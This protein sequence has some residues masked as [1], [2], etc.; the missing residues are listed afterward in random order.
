MKLPHIKK[1]CK[2]CPMRKDTTKGW[3]GE[4][5]MR[6]ILRAESF[7]CHKKKSMQCAGHMLIK[8][9]ENVFVAVAGRLGIKLDLAGADTV[10]QSKTACI[11]HH[12]QEGL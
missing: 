6:E 11:E 1:P 2:D 10:F 9:E 7:V 8:G 4:T 3:L 5:R 12:A